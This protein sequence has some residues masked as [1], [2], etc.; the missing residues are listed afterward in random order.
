MPHTKLTAKQEIFCTEYMRLDNASAAYRIAYSTAKT[1][2]KSVNENA[3]K[4]LKNTKVTTRVKELQDIAA[5]IA[6]DKFKVDST[7]LLHHLNTIRKASIEEY[8]EFYE[9]QHPTTVTTGRG[10]N[11]ETTTTYEKRNKLR[12]K[13]F[14]E[15][16]EDQK[17]CIKNIKEGRYG[18]ELELHSIEWSIE[19]IAKHI[20]FYAVGNKQ[21]TQE[22]QITTLQITLPDGKVLDDFSID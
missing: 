8:V 19:K 3:S 10:K 20:G 5:K 9:Y 14:D 7:E 22:V 11:K 17:R 1:K 2:D 13:A 16:T 15:L 21:K 18:T 4:L 12:V 6:E